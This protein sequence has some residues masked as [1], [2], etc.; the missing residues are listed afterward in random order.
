MYV[1]T[2]AYFNGLGVTAETTAFKITGFGYKSG[3]TQGKCST[4]RFC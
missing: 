1:A 2:I 3:C 4:M